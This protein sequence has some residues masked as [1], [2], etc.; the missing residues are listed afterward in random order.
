MPSVVYRETPQLWTRG[1]GA[2]VHSA[3]GLALQVPA[4]SFPPPRGLSRWLRADP[5]LS[6]WTATAPA[7][8]WA[9]ASSRPMSNRVPEVTPARGPQCGPPRPSPALWGPHGTSQVL[10]GSEGRGGGC[11]LPAAAWLEPKLHTF[12][13]PPAATGPTARPPR[14]PGS[15]SAVGPGLPPGLLGPH[16]CPGCA[17]PLVQGR[18]RPRDAG[19]LPPTPPLSRPWGPGHSFS[20]WTPLT[21]WGR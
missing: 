6:P 17:V 19:S 3:P 5:G 18:R 10:S 16:P 14:K 20:I 21:L 4:V 9:S 12:R 8:S 2:H 7:P 11:A 1:K 13:V 15:D